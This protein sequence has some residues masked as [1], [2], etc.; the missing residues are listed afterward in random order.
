MIGCQLL[1][2][3]SLA[4]WIYTLVMLVYAI[5]SWI[6]DIRGR[7]SE[8]LAMVVE[9]VV[10]PVRRLIPPAGG[11]DW[12]FLVVLLALQVLIRIINSYVTTSCYF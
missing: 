5:T 2:G 12:S 4:L 9:P 10:A 6:P 1:H 8:Y 11:F 7:W 3:I